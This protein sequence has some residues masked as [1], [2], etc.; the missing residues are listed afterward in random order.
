MITEETCDFW[1]SCAWA[2]GSYISW[3]TVLALI[4][5]EVAY[6]YNMSVYICMHRCAACM[7]ACVYQ[8]LLYTYMCVHTS[9][10]SASGDKGY[11]FLYLYPFY[12]HKTNSKR[13]VKILCQYSL[14]INRGKRIHS[15]WESLY[16]QDK[17]LCFVFYYISF[18]FILPGEAWPTVFRNYTGNVDCV[19][20]WH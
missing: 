18:T 5:R 8:Q 4:S 6:T 9:E 14:P 16:Q 19:L 12:A 2:S 15:P 20:M 13:W 3:A 1:S 11:I 7:S 10:R 17:R